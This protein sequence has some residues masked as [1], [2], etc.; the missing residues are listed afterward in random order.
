MHGIV[1]Y[2]QI[3]VVGDVAALSVRRLPLL[4]PKIA[5][6]KGADTRITAIVFDEAPAAA[7]G[8]LVSIV[9]RGDP[10]IDPIVIAI[11][12]GVARL[13]VHASFR[14]QVQAEC[15]VQEAPGIGVRIAAVGSR[16][17]WKLISS[18]I[19]ETAYRP[20]SSGVLGHAVSIRDDEGVRRLTR[21]CGG[22][23][24]TGEVGAFELDPPLH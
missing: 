7:H 6:L 11:R 4:A 15:L 12:V 24:N 5:I 18:A 21:R 19:R 1:A 20:V 2:A 8:L 10:V 14:R 16:G 23:R 13:A 3:A 9:P 17:C 22:R